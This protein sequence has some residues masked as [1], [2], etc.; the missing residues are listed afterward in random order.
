MKKDNTFD[1][2]NLIVYLYSWRKPLIG[3]S[4]LAAV[5]SAIFSAPF[6][7]PPKY[8][9]Q[10]ILFPSTT[11]SVSKALLDERNADQDILEFGKEEEAEQMLQ[12]LNSDEI[13]ERIIK[14]YDLLN[15]YEIDPED[16]Y[17]MTLLNK[18]FES[19]VSYNRT[20]FMSVS[21]EVMDTDPQ[22]A[23]D[24]ANDIAALVD[25]VKNR[26]QY[27]RALDGFKIVE[28]EYQDIQE[29]IEVLE[30]SLKALRSKGVLLYED[31]VAILTEQLAVAEIAGKS[32]VARNIQKKLDQ[33]AKFGGAQV[34]LS[35]RLML[36]TEDAALIRRKYK[37]AK[38][39]LE[40]QLSHKFVVNKAFKAE[41]KSYPV[42]WLIVVLSTLGAFVLCL[43]CI[44]VLDTLKKNKLA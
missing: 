10:V 8:K 2:S 4:L 26:I 41:K 31:Q 18:E 11:N 28:K 30:D 15:H 19:N 43:V 17:K 29:E 23:A 3:F 33:L 13:R 20:R 5:V 44:I 22:K 7:I 21:I 1:S 16:P 42:R 24:M 36:L 39:N 32:S 14:K 37:E 9:S 40:N 38:V 35:N 34:N 25:T 6:F 12:I 27:E